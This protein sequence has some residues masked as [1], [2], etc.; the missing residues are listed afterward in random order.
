MDP[1]DSL[2]TPQVSRDHRLKTSVKNK[3]MLNNLIS[4][5]DRITGLI[6]KRVEGNAIHIL[7]WG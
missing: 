7:T 3:A 6:D 4:F 5:F 2:Q 1:L